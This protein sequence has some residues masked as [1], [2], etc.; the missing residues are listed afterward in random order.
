MRR[1]HPHLF[2]LGPAERWGRL[3]RGST[4]PGR[5]DGP[6]PAL[7]SLLM[8]YRLQERA[9]RVG[10]DWPDAAGP[11]AKVREELAEVEASL[12][13]ASTAPPIA[14]TSGEP[15]LPQPETRSSMKSEIC[16]SRW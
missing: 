11:A 12:A 3:K 7:P 15:V 5:L 9:A 16:S 13:S 4:R 1:R 2:D 8:A 6:P 14:V 10:F